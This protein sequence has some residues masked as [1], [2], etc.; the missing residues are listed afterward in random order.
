MEQGAKILKKVLDE[1]IKKKRSQNAMDKI[2]YCPKCKKD[3]PA[4]TD[5]FYKD[6]KS[7][8]GLSCWCKDCQKASSAAAWEKKQAAKKTGTKPKQKPKQ[9]PKPE[10][11]DIRDPEPV[12]AKTDEYTLVLDFIDDERL[13][14]DIKAEACDQYRTPEMQ[15]MW[16]VVKSLYAERSQT[17]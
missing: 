3:K 11:F 2:Q 8:T 10:P 12:P 15:A 14:E 4:D 6:K 1:R 16:L 7:K 17:S 13:L 9:K 5:H